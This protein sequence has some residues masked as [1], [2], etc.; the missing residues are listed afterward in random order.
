M[1]MARRMKSALGFM[2]YMLWQNKTT[3]NLLLLPTT[4]SRIK[5]ARWI[6]GEL[7]SLGKTSVKDASS[8]VANKALGSNASNRPTLAHNPLGREASTVWGPG[9]ISSTERGRSWEPAREVRSWPNCGTMKSWYAVTPLRL[10]QVFRS[11]LCTELP[12]AVVVGR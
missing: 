7:A 4:L 5:G 3:S 9:P 2:P 1:V 8:L 12:T 11:R 10:A 6:M